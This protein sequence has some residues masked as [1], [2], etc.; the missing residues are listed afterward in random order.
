MNLD[1]E[2]QHL[3]VRGS[4]LLNLIELNLS[5]S[6]YHERLADLLSDMENQK[7][8]VTV[9]GEFKRGKSTLI[10]ALIHKDLLPADVT[11]TTATINV[12][13]NFSE[14][15]IHVHLENGEVFEDDL[16]TQQ[17]EK[18]SLSNGEDFSHI[19]HVDIH[20][21][22]EHVHPD[23]VLVDTPGVGDL[24]E[25][26]VDVTYS[27][28]PRST[29]VLFVIDCST[30]LR[31]TEI[32]YLKNHII[33][34]LYGE[35]IIVANYFDQIEEDEWEEEIEQDISLK[36]DRVL[37]STPYTL[38][39][40]SALGAREDEHD[41]KFKI[42]EAKMQKTI[43]TGRFNEQK[44]E[45]YERRLQTIIDG[46][47]AEVEKLH[48]LRNSSEADIH[49][50]QEKLY[51][52]KERG[53]QFKLD[54][55]MY[56]KDRKNEIETIIGNSLLHFE[57]K[58]TT[59]IL[60]EIEDYPGGKF[61]NF[62]EVQIP[63]RMQF[64]VNAWISHYSK[65][66]DV[67]LGKLEDRVNKGMSELIKKN[68]QSLSTSSRGYS[69]SNSSRIKLT[70]KDDNG[71][72]MSG[73][74]AGAGAA[75]LFIAGATGILPIIALVGYPILNKKI[76]EAKLKKAKEE[77]KMTVI[78]GVGNIINGLSTN[79][80]RY[81]NDEFVRL[82]IDSNREL[83]FFIQNYERDLERELS[84]KKKKIDTVPLITLKELDAV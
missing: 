32:N 79:I 5:N 56:L 1:V 80:H 67:L 78:R 41:K 54:L 4:N 70:G 58:L 25:H 2:M 72:I 45:F 84:N 66:I 52:F 17:L 8:I 31:R 28:I 77:A 22:M 15:K 19:H 53:G 38:I 46:L 50:E 13:H 55:K 62:V 60:Q 10:N 24:N 29:A 49:L 21:P 36:L 27:Y 61:K 82:E 26:R 75:A 68:F 83:K 51:A 47:K 18:L 23:L 3:I 64:E 43:E 74:F 20:M 81:V 9:L 57:E 34:N 37:E 65:N 73:A 48:A 71:S 39:P 63:K 12:I 30:S 6:L 7:H 42:L 35:L 33:P 40:L 14:S 11:P 59:L 44:I 76:S 69:Y 16:D